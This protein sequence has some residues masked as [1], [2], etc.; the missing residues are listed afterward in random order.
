VKHWCGFWWMSFDGAMSPTCFSC[1][2]PHAASLTTNTLL[3]SSEAE[4]V[5]CKIWKLRNL[6]YK[7]R[8]VGNEKLYFDITIHVI[9]I[10]H[11]Y[12]SYESHQR[13]RENMFVFVVYRRVI[14][15]NTKLQ[16]M[17]AKLYW[18]NHSGQLANHISCWVFHGKPLI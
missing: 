18:A 4:I 17:Y 9:S 12:M 11:S 5:T 15:S 2:R 7:L 13:K 6:K 1:W 8:H 3:T 10:W 16:L 14:S